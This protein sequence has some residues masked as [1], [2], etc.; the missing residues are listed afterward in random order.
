MA[1]CRFEAK[2]ISR[3]GGRSSVGAASYR[4]GKCA[5]SAAAYRAAA[6]LKDERTG[7]VYDYTRKRG[8]MGAEIM[9]PPGAPDWMRDRGQL[10]N[11]VEKVEKRADAQLA[12]DHILTLPFEL[13][14]EQRRELTRA[15][16]R[17]QFTDKGYVADIAWHAP[18]GK[19]DERNFHAHVMVVMRRIEGNGFARTK[20]RPPD[21]KHPAEHWK[22]ELR[23]Q[24]EAWANAGA[25]ALALAGFEIEAVRFRAG[26][27]TLDKQREAAV[28]RGDLVWAAALDREAE[29][30]QGPLATK[31]EQQGRESHAGSDRR[32]V[33]ARNA[34]RANLQAEHAAVTAQIIDLEQERLK[35]R[36]VDETAPQ[37]AEA[38]PASAPAQP[39]KA[40]PDPVQAPEPLTPDRLKQQHQEEATRLRQVEAITAEAKKFEAAKQQE[41]E[42]AK[43]TEGKRREQDEAR[44][45][46]GDI[47]NAAGRYAQAL[48][49]NYDIRDPYGSLA[50]A[51]MSEYG[52]FQR[53]QQELHKEIAGEKDP[54]KREILQL[55]QQIEAHDYMA[56]GSERQAEISAIIAGRENS[57]IAVQDRAN[58]AHYR[59]EATKL[60][61]QRS[62]LQAA[63]RKAER[64]RVA[65]GLGN[66]GKDIGRGHAGQPSEAE[67]VRQ[68]DAETKQREGLK[69]N[70]GSEARPGNKES[71]VVQNRVAEEH[72]A[73]GTSYDP[74]A[75]TPTPAQGKGAGK[76]GGKGR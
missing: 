14:D 41:A 4:T 26:H 20:E 65:E 11:A 15:F 40:T 58:A 21:G 5:T 66:L 13:S 8:V 37:K 29:P 64:G 25:D 3:S 47:N 22:A 73:A 48:G 63:E 43:R 46:A 49:N 55:R 30:K 33:K 51:A 10:W 75:Q 2:I 67:I 45:A 6:E 1:L 27:M 42:E 68:Q 52:M 62:E 74:Q 71:R 69:A 60:R 61:E 57:P 72:A 31:I 16:V 7:V 44:A 59:Q 23:Q 54:A 24:R 70:E 34:E 17:E 9:L 53:Q 39:A 28:A 36:M 32:D 50:K 76:G 38:A 18:H 19:G 35:R 56:V 12:R